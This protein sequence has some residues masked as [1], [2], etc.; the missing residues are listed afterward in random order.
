MD[1]IVEYYMISS[2]EYKHKQKDKHK[3]KHKDKQIKPI[4]CNFCG[5][6]MYWCLCIYK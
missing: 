4:T 1:F 2:I 3:D 6:N 5:Q